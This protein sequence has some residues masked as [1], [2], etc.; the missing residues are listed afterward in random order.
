MLAG[1]ALGAIAGRWPVP[2]ALALVQDVVL[3]LWC[4]TV[5]NVASTVG[6]LGLLLR[7]W[8]YVSI[9]WV[10]LMIV[11]VMT[12]TTV[13][14]GQTERQGHRAQLTLADPSYAANYFFISIMVIWATG[15]PRRR[16]VRIV[17]YAL[18][19]IGIALTG[20]NSG[21]LSVV[22]GTVVATSI[23]TYRRFGWVAAV[24]AL[25]AMVVAAA[26][27][28]STVSLASIQD[29]ASAS[30]YGFIRDGI[31][32]GTSVEQRGT[33][34]RESLRLY[35]DGSL[36]GEGP[37][38]TK[39]RLRAEMAPFEKE[40]HDD[41]LAALIERGV[42]GFAGIL[43]LV[44]ALLSRMAVLARAR[45]G[46]VLAVARPNALVGAAAGTLVAGTVYELLHVRHVWA[47]FALLAAASLR[48]DGSR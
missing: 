46:I 37:V 44:A 29:R 5:A 33:L 13:L 26:L 41:Y 40:A 39:P 35:R 25:G 28:S 2:G 4:W 12:H 8:A 3:V 9:V 48:R 31:G 10:L 42:V 18:L 30:R 27:V 32:R 38:S 21:V 1:G 34:L 47:L 14:S 19:L 45:T 22:T 23:G 7:T 6:R 15:R 20:S 43:A 11:G 17:A 16:S 36:L 24:G